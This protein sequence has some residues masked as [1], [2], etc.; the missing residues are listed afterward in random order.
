[1]FTNGLNIGLLLWAQI[2]KTV[3]GVETV[4]GS[5]V[6]KGGQTDSVLGHQ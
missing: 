3:H 6:G 4:P 1:M 5:A 2:K